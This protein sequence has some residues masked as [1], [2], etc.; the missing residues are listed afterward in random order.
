[1]KR[2]LNFIL[3]IVSILV[4][5]PN[6]V[7]QADVDN[8]IRR[9]MKDELD[10]NM[11]DLKM[12]DQG[13]PFFIS[14][15]L[16]DNK[17]T[18]VYASLGSLV[19]T[20][21]IP[22]RRYSVRVMIGDYLF[23]DE[24][25]NNEAAALNYNYYNTGRMWEIPIE[26]DYYGIRRSFWSGTDE[27][28]KRATKTYKY[29]IE[30]IAKQ[31]TVSE[32]IPHRKFAKVPVLKIQE[33]IKNLLHSQTYLEEKAVAISELFLRYPS[34]VS[35]NIRISS[36][37]NNWYFVSSEGADIRTSKA[38]TLFQIQA[39]AL[40]EI[41]VPVSRSLEYYILKSEE[42]PEIDSIAAD[43]DHMV[44]QMKSTMEAK[45]FD[46]SYEGP[47]LFLDRS[48]PTLFN[49]IFSRFKASDIENDQGN[50]IFNNPQ[51]NSSIDS[52]INKK[53]ISSDLSVS[54]I[55]KTDAYKGKPLIGSYIVDNEGVEPKDELLLVEN[56]VL[57]NVMTSRTLAKAHHRANGTNSGPGVISVSSK[58][59][60][61]QEELKKKLIELAKAEE[62]EYA[63]IV[64]DLRN[65]GARDA[66]IYKVS[67]ENG[68][69]EL[70]SGAELQPLNLKVLKKINGVAAEREAFNFSRNS[71]ICPVGILL[72]GID[73]E[74]KNWGSYR[75]KNPIV[76]NPLE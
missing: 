25:L 60:M 32:K 27:V 29:H 10:R 49:K 26:D 57:K 20:S 50:G 16:F 1:M 35:S 22:V 18:T 58:N 3:L 33:P 9:A 15:Q 64:R 38:S 72:D 28:Y 24:S 13:P 56:G 7:G 6:A 55:P 70:L 59:I 47:V 4:V 2:I 14:Y 31:D 5:I 12:E 66:A 17:I 37:V 8:T 36:F 65:N 21:T 53:I 75:L 51:I 34:L 74:S 11:S 76:K 43:I 71:I 73:V 46:D 48:V 67:L 42:F 63:I 41:G 23:N 19:H 39:V 62:L 68:T 54:L 45:R 30:R 44:K 40:S 61:T 69:E 52:K